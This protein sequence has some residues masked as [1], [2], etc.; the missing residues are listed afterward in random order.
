M[1]LIETKIEVGDKYRKIFIILFLFFL[2]QVKRK[3]LMRR[4]IRW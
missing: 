3:R 1:K 4:K 2:N